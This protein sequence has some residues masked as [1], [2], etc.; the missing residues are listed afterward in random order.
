MWARDRQIPRVF[1]EKPQTQRLHSLVFRLPMY[2]LPAPF[3]RV[4]T[5]GCFMA[6]ATAAFGIFSDR[7]ST[8]NA[9]ETLRA[10]GFRNTDILALFPDEIPTQKFSRRKRR[11]AFRHAA[12]GGGA[13]MVIGGVL[14][15]I[16]GASISTIGGLGAMVSM[17]AG[18]S[19]V[20]AWAARRAPDYES[21]YEGR[22]R[23]GDILI[24]VL[25]DDL[26]WAKKAREILKR[27]G[28]DDVSSTTN[29]PVQ[30][31]R[32]SRTA[33]PRPLIERTVASPPLRLV[34]NR[35]LEAPGAA[36]VVPRE[37]ASSEV[38]TK[39]VAS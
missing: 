15:W 30:L 37:S 39:S 23:R 26:H 29:V 20:A 38:H 9:I 36:M 32:P 35:N 7:I 8:E 25:C 18:G 14:E 19:F 22:V 2:A 5:K 31:I 11:N 27:A 1:A 6:V 13:A 16:A 33:A 12:A 21:R 17:G 4:A 24:S 34:S 28:G 3:W 10:A